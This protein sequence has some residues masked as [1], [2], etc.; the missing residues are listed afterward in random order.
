MKYK[1]G[2]KDNGYHEI[3]EKINDYFEEALSP[4]Y[5]RI[6]LEGDLKKRGIPDVMLRFTHKLEGGGTLDVDLLLSPHWES[7]EDFFEAL[8]GMTD[9][10]RRM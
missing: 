3:L 10:Q 7:K 2:I 1:E 4:N 5:T 8:R 6:P 9:E